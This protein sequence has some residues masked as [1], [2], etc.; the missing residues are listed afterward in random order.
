MSAETHPAQSLATPVGASEVIAERTV[1]SKLFQFGDGV[2]MRKTSMGQIHYK[3]D[4]TNRVEDWKE[5][6]LVPDASLRV[7]RVP[8]I[9]QASQSE[10][11]FTYTS[12]LGGVYS[13]RLIEVGTSG[14]AVPIESLNINP[15]VDGRRTYWRDLLPGL[16]VYILHTPM[17][18][19][20]FKV[21]HNDAAPT[22]FVWEVISDEPAQFQS[23]HRSRAVDKDKKRARMTMDIVD[24]GLVEG[25]RHLRITEQFER[26]TSEVINL[27]TRERKWV[28][29]FTY[30]I[31]IDVPDVTEDINA[32][33]DDGEFH[34]NS[35]Q[36]SVTYFN[37]VGASYI[38]MGN[39][40][41]SVGYAGGFR[42]SAVA[43]P[44]GATITLAEL[45]LEVVSTPSNNPKMDVRG[46]AAD[47]AL[48]WT[49]ED[50][51]E[52]ALT[53]ASTAWS[54]T[55]GSTTVKIVVTDIIDE[56]IGRGGFSSG[57]AVKLAAMPIQTGTA[58]RDVLVKPYEISQGVAAHLE[59]TYTVA[60]DDQEFSGTLAERS[61]PSTHKFPVEVVAY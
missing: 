47:N 51:L 60:N 9:A 35:V 5:I 12:R 37:L 21:L 8:Y 41:A 29:G 6:D 59:V 42:F 54:Q 19:E 43:V 56:I 2:M 57:N 48:D 17:G 52:M 1:Q 16:D 50:T 13:A 10:V 32:G 58:V 55:A 49:T 14:E 31:S 28:D 4:R 40:K 11:G 18:V 25:K 3:E 23:A 30:P 53:T 45:V 7:S 36:T 61:D 27:R 39:Y 22:R 38:R 20:F 15:T 33:S 44:Q 34:H 24:L 46:N 26:Q